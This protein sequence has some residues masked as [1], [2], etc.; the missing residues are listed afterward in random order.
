MSLNLPPC[1]VSLID[2][3]MKAMLHQMVRLPRR[4]SRATDESGGFGALYPPAIVSTT[5]SEPTDSG[6]ILV[7][8]ICVLVLSSTFRQSSMVWMRFVGKRIK[9]PSM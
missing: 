1:K 2:Y 6:F 4:G 5:P 3:C 9:L 7:L 8:D